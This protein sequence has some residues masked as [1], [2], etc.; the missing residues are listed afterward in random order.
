[1][2]DIGAQ[3]EILIEGKSRSWRDDKAIAMEA[4]CY[5]KERN[6]TQEVA[7]RNWRD[8]SLTVIGWH[9]GRAFIKPLRAGPATERPWLGVTRILPTTAPRNGRGG[10]SQSGLP[11]HSR[12]K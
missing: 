12:S 10:T 9:D 3:F 1:M 11:W 8:N 7:V 2:T 5:L 4:G 6:P